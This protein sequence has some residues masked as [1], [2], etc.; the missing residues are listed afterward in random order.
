MSVIG[1]NKIIFPVQSCL[2]VCNVGKP[3]SCQIRYVSSTGLGTYMFQLFLPKLFLHCWSANSLQCNG[4]WIWSVILSPHA[5]SFLGNFV[6]HLRLQAGI[7]VRR[8]D[9]LW[10][11]GYSTYELVGRCHSFGWVFAVYV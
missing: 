11:L 10:W 9:V 7:L 2:E 3:C 8:V 6:L 4:N 5:S 1:F